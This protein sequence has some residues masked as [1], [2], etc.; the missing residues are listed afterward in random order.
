MLMQGTEA[1]TTPKP[2]TAAAPT[3]A[4][5]TEGAEAIDSTIR[6]AATSVERQVMDW[7]GHASDW[8]DGRPIASHLAGIGVLLA[9]AAIALLLV[10]FVVGPVLRRLTGRFGHGVMPHLVNHRTMASAA[11]V[12]A[13]LVGWGLTPTLAWISAPV[14]QLV[15]NLAGAVFA[16]LAARLVSSLVGGTHAYYRTRQGG[17][18]QRSITSFVQLGQLLVWIV[19]A[20]FAISLLLDRSPALLLSG[21]GA[22]AAIIILVFRDTLLSLVA[23]IQ[24][25]TN[26][27]VR[28]GDWI[29]SPKFGADG[30][31]LDIGLNVVNVQN[32]DKTITSIPTF[33][34]IDE[35]FT[36]WRGM[37]ESG[38]R[39][40]KRSLLV[41]VQTVR[42]LR[43]DEA[44]DLARMSL[45][46]EYMRE[47]LDEIAK[48]NDQAARE[49]SAASPPLEPQE[50]RLTNLGTFR[51]YIER[52]LQARADVRKDM[53]LLVRHL[54]PTFDGLPIEVYC[55]TATTNWNAYESIQADI[56][57]H[58]LA[59]AP[60]FGL[61]IVQRPTG[62]D[63]A[64]AGP[65]EAAAAAG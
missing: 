58:L 65:R 61:R 12:S 4:P 48:A 17:A 10:R 42:F 43:E 27:L 34:L 20:I 55:F 29:S 40:I 36:N 8:L 45:I 28:V 49:A 24:V 39:R 30:Y 47:K 19:G 11:W 5:S 41:D 18:P 51:A 37:T 46:A 14:R 52:Y 50:R 44:S 9:A 25:S 2:A 57:D 62:E 33:K 22:A 6:D 16:I 15:E 63:V 64:A 38:G 59:T 32:F 21:L 1:K 56:F 31:V 26:D 3:N 60:R 35:A 54:D 23:A 13:A 7:V 53:T